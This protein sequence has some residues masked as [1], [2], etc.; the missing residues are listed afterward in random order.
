M[1]GAHVMAIGADEI[2]SKIMDA[3]EGAFKDGWVVVKSYA[4][5]EFSKMAFQ[6]EE[7]ANNVA[8]YVIDPNDGYSP[9]TGKI[10]FRMQR[11]ACESVLV[12]V[13]KLSLITIQTAIN[14]IIQVLNEAFASFLPGV[15]TA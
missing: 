12:A 2:L 4:A 13:T 11:T 3:A 6:L 15:L 1:Q 9:E 10:L 7:I 14:A 5:A 8:K